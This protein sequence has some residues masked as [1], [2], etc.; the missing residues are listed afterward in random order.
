MPDEIEF[1]EQGEAEC[2][3]LQEPSYKGVTVNLCKK[4]SD[5]RHFKITGYVRAPKSPEPA[6]G[7]G[8]L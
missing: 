8:L 2:G 5:S 1:N 6:P 7:D 3:C 4:H